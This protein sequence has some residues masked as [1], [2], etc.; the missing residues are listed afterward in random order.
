MDNALAQQA[1]DLLVEINELTNELAVINAAIADSVKVFKIVA[2]RG[3]G[4][5]IVVLDR[6][7]SVNRS[8]D[9]LND[10]KTRTENRLSNRQAAL[11]A[12]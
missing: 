10:L 9:L 2:N 11:A 4:G 7:L 5:N 1:S 8:A 3:G 12:L 6:E